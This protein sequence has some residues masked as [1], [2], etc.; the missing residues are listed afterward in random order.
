MIG[1]EEHGGPFGGK[2]GISKIIK[3]YCSLTQPLTPRQNDVWL[4]TDADTNVLIKNTFPSA[5]KVGDVVT[6]KV[7]SKFMNK[8]SIAKGN[9]TVDVDE[10]DGI[11]E[12]NKPLILDTDYF[13]FYS[14]LS[15]V[16]KKIS[17]VEWEAIEGYWFNN[18]AWVQFSSTKNK[19]IVT[20]NVG[21]NIG[22]E[23]ALQDSLNNVPIKTYK[24]NTSD[25]SV[26]V[27]QYDQKIYRIINGTKKVTV[28]DYELNVVGTWTVP[29]ILDFSA[30]NVQTIVGAHFASKT[31]FMVANQILYKYDCAAG[32]IVA[33]MTIGNFRILGWHHDK[34]NKRIFLSDPG[35]GSAGSFGYLDEDVTSFT[36]LINSVWIKGFVKHPVD[37]SIYY[38]FT[39]EGTALNITHK[40]HTYTFPEMTLQ[41][42][43]IITGIGNTG[44]IVSPVAYV[45]DAVAFRTP[46]GTTQYQK[47]RAS[48]LEPI[49]TVGIPGGYTNVTFSHLE[50]IFCYS[51][52]VETGAASHGKMQII[53]TNG[54]LT[55]QS[56]NLN[57]EY[58]KRTEQ[59]MRLN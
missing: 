16:I 19:I 3:V 37:S 57:L 10:L 56:N 33:Q 20:N 52:S 22:S 35:N 50:S 28:L 36:R 42:I 54:I 46:A 21:P 45:G 59:A 24:S 4:K 1:I 14:T 15:H 12:I 2:N 31:L 55:A 47:R 29:T 44:D 53:S 5:T 13:A 30:V 23:I 51:D 32:R 25:G 7:D 38:L 9:L 11:T 49:W 48:D 40:L 27:D 39:Q 6:L 41:S 18:G 17:D 34:N 26:Y 58:N 43:K 8:G